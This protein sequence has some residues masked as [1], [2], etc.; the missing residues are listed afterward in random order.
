MMSHL[1]LTLRQDALL[2]ASLETTIHLLDL[3]LMNSIHFLYQLL[4]TQV[5]TFLQARTSPVLLLTT[6][7]TWHRI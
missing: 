3:L 1:N 4:R 6:D 5:I 2:L 7:M